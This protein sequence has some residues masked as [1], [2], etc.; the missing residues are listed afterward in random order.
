ME[1][2]GRNVKVEELNE[3]RIEAV[4]LRLAGVSVSETA[5]KTSLSEPTVT[6]A[7]KAYRDGGWPAVPVAPRGRGI[8]RRDEP[9]QSKDIKHLSESSRGYSR[10]ASLT[11][12]Q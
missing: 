10:L 11:H 12:L 8:K 7:L 3:R 6:A 5:N 9:S 4:R 1:L 2:D